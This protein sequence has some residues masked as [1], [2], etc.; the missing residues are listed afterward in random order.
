MGRPLHLQHDVG[1]GQQGRPVG[2]DG[3][4]GSRVGVVGHG[5][6]ATGI[7]FDGNREAERDEALDRIR[8]G[9]D[10]GFSRTTLF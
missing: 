9:G 3:G 10:P 7:G 6:A 4:A 5:G 8:R 2:D 1:I